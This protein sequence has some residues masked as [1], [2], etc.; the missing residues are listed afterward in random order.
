M[1]L[2][3][4]RNCRALVRQPA[5]PEASSTAICNILQYFPRISSGLRVY[6]FSWLSRQSIKEAADALKIFAAFCSL[7]AWIASSRFASNITASVTAS[8]CLMRTTSAVP[9]GPLRASSQLWTVRSLVPV[10][11]ARCFT[12][13]GMAPKSAFSASATTSASKAPVS[14]AG[15]NGNRFPF[16]PR[17]FRSSVEKDIPPYSPYAERVHRE[18]CPTR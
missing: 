16:P 1:P 10:R 15:S 8:E 14:A 3:G 11:R 4:I 6:P 18:R 9:L 13:D 17:S 5:A 7:F 12:W 2:S